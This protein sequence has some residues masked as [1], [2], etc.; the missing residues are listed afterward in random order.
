MTYSTAAAGMVEVAK[1]EELKAEEP[2]AG[3]DMFYSRPRAERERCEGFE[4]AVKKTQVERAPLKTFVGE[5]P[6]NKF[7]RPE[8]QHRPAAAANHSLPRGVLSLV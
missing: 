6:L 7:R 1:A 2:K 3:R 8:S 4:R 5:E